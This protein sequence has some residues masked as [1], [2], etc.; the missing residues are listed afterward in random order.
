MV[1]TRPDIQPSYLPTPDEIKAGCKRAQDGWTETERKTRDCYP[2]KRWEAP[3]AVIA[4]VVE[5][6]VE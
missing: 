3:G 5:Q 4:G 6:E 1:R 2:V